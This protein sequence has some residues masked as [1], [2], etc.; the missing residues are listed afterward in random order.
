[1]DDFEYIESWNAAIN[2]NT[3]PETLARLANDKFWFV[4]HYVARNPSTQQYLKDYLKIR[5]FLN[6]HEL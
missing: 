6:P 5:E 2:H 1:M 4:R 3:L